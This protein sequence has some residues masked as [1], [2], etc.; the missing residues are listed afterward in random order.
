MLLVCNSLSQIVRNKKRHFQ[1]IFVLINVHATLSVKIDSK[2]FSRSFILF[3]GSGILVPSPHPQ[4]MGS[5]VDTLRLHVSEWN[6]PPAHNVRAS[7]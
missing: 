3:E 7:R 2:W 5:Q 4:H 1:K 6:G